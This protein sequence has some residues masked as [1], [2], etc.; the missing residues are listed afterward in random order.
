[1]AFILTNEAKIYDPQILTAALLHDIIEDT[2]TTM[3]ELNQLFGKEVHDI[4]K[5]C[6]LLP[7]ISK[8]E[9]KKEFI[10]NANIL[11][12]KVNFLYIFKG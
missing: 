12:N 5:E 6:T 8:K 7:G 9:S 11:S 10:L 4:V 3:E 1:M 2:K